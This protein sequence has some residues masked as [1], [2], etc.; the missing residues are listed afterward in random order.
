M[1]PAV[2]LSTLL[3]VT[4][5]TLG[6]G[7]GDSEPPAPPP[8]DTCKPTVTLDVLPGTY[9]NAVDLGGEAPLEVA[10]L[11]SVALDAATV[12][13]ATA[14]LR[15]PDGGAAPVAAL[16]DSSARDVDGDGR[17]D[18]IL[19]F[20]VQTLRSAGV[21][22]AESSRLQLSARTRA[23]A[24]VTGCDR[25]HASGHRLMELPAPTGAHAVGT[26][27]YHWTDSAR[28]ERLTEA[29]DDK[30]ELM[31]RLWYPAVPASSAQ[32]TAYFLQRR[33]GV[34]TATGL[35]LP[36]RYFD[37]VHAHAVEG[38]PVSQASPRWPVV[39]FSPGSGVSTAL[40]TSLLEDLASRGYVVA[41]ISHTYTTGP[42]V[43][44]DGR[45]APSTHEPSPFDG[46]M[47][48]TLFDMWTADAR[49]VLERLDALDASDERGLFT[50]RLDLE[51]L[52]MLGHSFGGANAAAVSQR[53]PRLK[54][55][56]NLDGTFQG[57]S[58]MG[59]DIPFLLMNAG[60]AK[61]GSQEDFLKATRGTTYHTAV[62]RAEH[63]TFTDLPL[64]LEL[65]K[66][67]QPDT[68]E[69]AL[70]VGA[71][72]ARGDTVVRAYVG[73]FLDKHLRGQPAPLLEGNAAE[74][75]EVKLTRYR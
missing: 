4:A 28:E 35:Q 55:G 16:P 32:P 37:Y 11:G 67:Y 3:A 36:E 33:E 42:V 20:S 71:L 8:E 75:P 54:A 40:Y 63:N 61:D 73:A 43:F 14:T 46:G 27:A 5:L 6:T 72:G 34:A 9:P 2:P 62:Q 7:C 22:H 52:G 10:V 65:M 1:R 48:R 25:A 69:E 60:D 70:D 18:V 29:A 23:G 68:D 39:L 51:H 45:F 66:V 58:P 21:L 74:F 26:A 13:P 12:D 57:D 24:E 44:P 59:V 50:G 53:E 30:R 41:A 49:F 64:L 31:V 17:P 56:A 19:R 47:T 15:D 38:A